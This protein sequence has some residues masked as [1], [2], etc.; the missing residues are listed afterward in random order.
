M[1]FLYA[2]PVVGCLALAACGI[3]DVLD[4]G[5]SSSTSATTTTTDASSDAANTGTPIGALCAV[6]P[7]SGETL[8]RAVS[9][10]PDVV[11]D[12]ETFPHCGF[13]VRGASVELVCGCSELICSMGVYSTCVQAQALLGNQT[14][15]SVCVQVAEDRCTKPLTTSTSSSSSTSS[16]GGTCD[17]ACLSECGGGAACAS[18]CGC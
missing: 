14:E 4:T 18:V 12:S 13:R 2:I 10:C 1:R 7:I 17:K 11:V 6:E 16:S 15:Q 3:A 8:C 5:T 9:T